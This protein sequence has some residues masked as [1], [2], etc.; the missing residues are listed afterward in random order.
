MQNSKLANIMLKYLPILAV[1]AAT[2]IGLLIGKD[3]YPTSLDSQTKTPAT[4]LQIEPN[5]PQSPRVMG[6]I[7]PCMG[8]FLSLPPKC[9]TVE[10]EFISVPGT[11][12]YIL[13]SSDGK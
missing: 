7:G 2:V 10:G 11:S 12:S 6:T 13:L 1:L 3:L 8:I 9:K 5:N 4:Q